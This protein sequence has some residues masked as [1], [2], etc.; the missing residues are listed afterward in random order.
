[1]SQSLDLESQYTLMNEFV[2]MVLLGLDEPWSLEQRLGGRADPGESGSA[3]KS[4]R[5]TPGTTYGDIVIEVRR[6]LLDLA[7]DG[8]RLS[9][10]VHSVLPDSLGY[11]EQLP[12]ITPE[13]RADL[14]LVCFTVRRAEQATPN[15]RRIIACIRGHL[16]GQSEDDRGEGFYQTLA[17]LGD[18][19]LMPQSKELFVHAVYYYH[20]A[21]SHYW[22]QCEAGRPVSES[23]N[24]DG[25]VRVRNCVFNTIIIIMEML[26]RRNSPVAA[27]GLES[28]ARVGVMCQARILQEYSATDVNFASRLLG[29]AR[30]DVRPVH[31]ACTEAM[32]RLHAAWPWLGLLDRPLLQVAAACAVMGKDRSDD[33]VPSRLFNATVSLLRARNEAKDGAGNREDAELLS[34]F[35]GEAAVRARGILAGL[36]LYAALSEGNGLADAFLGRSGLSC[37]VNF[38][39]ACSDLKLNESELAGLKELTASMSA[40]AVVA[41]TL[42]AGARNDI[43]RLRA[44]LKEMNIP[45]DLPEGGRYDRDRAVESAKRALAALLNGFGSGATTTFDA[46]DWR[47][48]VSSAARL[49]FV[50]AFGKEYVDRANRLLLTQVERIVSESA[51]VEQA[52]LAAYKDFASERWGEPGNSPL[53]KVQALEINQLHWE[54]VAGECVI[55]TP[56]L[57]DAIRQGDPPDWWSTA[58]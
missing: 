20:E 16:D 6:S 46:A 48:D 38:Y 39:A 26:Q 35:V 44:S 42:P 10:F 13:N 8:A 52:F 12:G 22:R 30:D 28:I 29:A 47:E 23:R 9:V 19:L 40:L 57:A 21:L 33:S 14:A 56:S 27:H 53:V 55:K 34:A 49:A 25:I 1:M 58:G 43:D 54:R 24:E 17:G 45:F 15:L 37:G 2:N 4:S 11:I 50:S 32:A 18:V 31:L 51:D 7:Q 5:I 36:G 3:E 41:S